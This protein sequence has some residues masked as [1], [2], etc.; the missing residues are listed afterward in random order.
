M[1]SEDLSRALR[2][3]VNGIRWD[4]FVAAR[5]EFDSD[6]ARD[7]WDQ[8]SVEVAAMEDR[9]VVPMSALVTGA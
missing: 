7:T 6:E 3:I 8:I 9:G 4:A 1:D 5:P 2:A